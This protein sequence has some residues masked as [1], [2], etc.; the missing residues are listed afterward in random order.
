M[1][2][3][4]HTLKVV[5]QGKIIEIVEQEGEKTIKV[6]LSPC[7]IDIPLGN[8]NESHLGDVISVETSLKIRNVE[9]AVPM[10]E[11]V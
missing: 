7:A 3:S 6:N 4:N 10:D 2:S 1:T 9:R 5:F 11:A 8:G